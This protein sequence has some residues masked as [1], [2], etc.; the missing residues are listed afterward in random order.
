[1]NIKIKFKNGKEYVYYSCSCFSIDD[2]IDFDFL[3]SID[4]LAIP[5][6]AYFP[7]TDVQ[8]IFILGDDN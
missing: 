7:L 1:M 5:L 2:D 6:H 4:D 3:D 8:C